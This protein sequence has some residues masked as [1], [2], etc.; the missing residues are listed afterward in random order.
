[1]LAVN[2]YYIDLS[3]TDWN[4][5]PRVLILS[6]IEYDDNGLPDYLYFTNTSG[7][8]VCYGGIFQLSEMIPLSN[9]KPH[10]ETL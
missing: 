5:P 1:M 6:E 3:P 2:T 8:L 9:L 7:T 10:K 4:L